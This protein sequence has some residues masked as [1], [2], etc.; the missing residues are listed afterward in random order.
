M[1]VSAEKVV[2]AGAGETRDI[3]WYGLIADSQYDIRFLLDLHC[4]RRSELRLL[5]FR[6]VHMAMV[7]APVAR[8]IHLFG[9]HLFIYF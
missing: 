5:H 1:E 4:Q 7:A 2:D 8:D 6:R 9:E 3:T